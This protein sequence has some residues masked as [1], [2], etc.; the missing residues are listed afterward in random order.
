[1]ALL[2]LGFKDSI[3][4]AARSLV[5]GFRANVSRGTRF[6]GLRSL[7]A[8]A[9]SASR[10]P[11]RPVHA[12]CRAASDYVRTRQHQALTRCWTAVSTR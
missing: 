11:A 7:W 9:R 2:G 6:L 3:L 4:A 12:D 10:V 5:K 8:R 1:M